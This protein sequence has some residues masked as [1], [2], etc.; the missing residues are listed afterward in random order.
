MDGPQEKKKKEAQGMNSGSSVSRNWKGSSH[1]EEA[2][3]ESVGSE[4]RARVKEERAALSANPRTTQP[5]EGHALAF[6]QHRTQAD[7]LRDRI[8]FFF[9]FLFYF[10]KKK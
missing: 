1:G 5:G 9:S 7:N 6:L 3:T 10:M 4:R 8:N 2:V